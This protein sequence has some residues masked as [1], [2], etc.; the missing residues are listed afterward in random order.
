LNDSKSYHYHILFF[1]FLQVPLAGEADIFMLE[2]HEY[3]H[4]IKV[5]DEGGGL[6][7]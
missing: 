1:C 4:F 5:L 6:L 3:L 7:H 2:S